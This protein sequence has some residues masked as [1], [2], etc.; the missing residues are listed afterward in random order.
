MAVH[1]HVN[2]AVT[3]DGCLGGP[4][5]TP[6][7]ISNDEDLRRVHGLRNSA[8]AILVGVGTVIADNP[9]LTVKRDLVGGPVKDPL[10]VVLDPALRTPP[11]S[12]VTRPEVPTLFFA[13]T[14]A[15]ERAGW[16]VERVRSHVD[17]LELGEVLQRLE[18]YGVRRLIVEGG[19][20]TLSRFFYHNHVD[21]A[22]IFVA[23]RILGAPD[24]PRLVEG[25]MDLR[26]HLALAEAHPLGDGI[27]FALRRR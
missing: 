5:R 8:D 13:R 4:G 25:A 12:H 10:R 18:A 22:T 26:K 6:L 2:C 23:P 16:T 9:R 3:L 27:L 7:K 24:A 19:A 14:D 21:E 20:K 17:G 15:P 11:G 1:V